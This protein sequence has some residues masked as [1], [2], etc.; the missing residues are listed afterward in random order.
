[1][2]PYIRSLLAAGAILLLP[3]FSWA[4][5]P[6]APLPAQVL[7]KGHPNL[8]A[9][10]QS[11]PPLTGKVLKTMNSGG[12]TYMYLQ[13]KKGKKIWVAI[14]KSKVAVGQNIELVPGEELKKFKSETLKRTFDT[15]VFSLGPV[16]AKTAKKSS[17]PM[18]TTWGSKG[19]MVAA[20]KVTVEK[21]TGGKNTYTIAELFAQK[22]ALNGKQVVIRGKIVKVVPRIMKM[23]WVHLQDGTGTA[24]MKNHDLVVKTKAT[25]T[26]GDTVTVSGMLL[27]DKDYGSGYKYDVLIDNGEIIK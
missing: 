13:Q 7:P 14:P 25:P 17:E 4:A 18:Y 10:Q 21:A 22:T 27:K 11:S 15:I 5:D 9:P 26:M 19:A 16:P 1:M 24:G 3:A 23:N 2:S 12:Y 8:A 6:A 20:E